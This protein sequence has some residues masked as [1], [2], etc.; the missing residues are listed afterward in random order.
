MKKILALLLA[1]AVLASMLSIS[2]LGLSAEDFSDVPEDS[3]YYEDVDFMAL[4]EYMNGFPD[5]TFRPQD[6]LTREQVA[7]IFARVWGADVSNNDVAPYDDVTPGRYSAG[8]IQWLKDTGLTTGT[9]NNKFSPKGTL[10]RQELATFTARFVKLYLEQHPDVKLVPKN[11][12]DGFNDMDKAADW[13]VESIEYCREQGL[14]YGFPDGDFRPT[15]NTTRA[16][17][18]AVFHRM[19]IE[20]QIVPAEP[21][22]GP[23]PGPVTPDEIDPED[24]IGLA[25]KAAAEHTNEGIIANMNGSYLRDYAELEIKDITRDGWSENDQDGKTRELTLEVNGSLDPDIAVKLLHIASNVLLPYLKV[26]N[27]DWITTETGD[28]KDEV[29]KA[30]FHDYAQSLVDDF[31]SLTGLELTG[32]DAKELAQKLFDDYK[33]TVAYSQAQ[34]L[35]NAEQ[36]IYRECFLNDGLYV[37]GEAVINVNGKDIATVNV[38]KDGKIA[39]LSISKWTAIKNFTLEMA[40]E[41]YHSLQT[42]RTDYVHTLNATSTVKVTFADSAVTEVSDKTATF[43][44]DYVLN[45]KV[46]MSSDLFGYKFDTSYSSGRNCVAVNL[47]TAFMD[48]LATDVTKVLNFIIDKKYDELYAKLVKAAG[49]ELLVKGIF[50]SVSDAAGGELTGENL[51]AAVTTVLGDTYKEEINTLVTYVNS[52][53]D[54]L[55]DYMLSRIAYRIN[56]YLDPATEDESEAL[57][58]AMLPVVTLGDIAAI[59]SNPEL[60]S[61]ITS[62]PFKPIDRVKG[63]IKTYLPD[64]ASIYI[65]EGQ[66]EL[67]KAILGDF[68]NAAGTAA[69]VAEF[70]KLVNASATLQGLSL[71]SLHDSPLLIGAK[72]GSYG[73]KHFRLAVLFDGV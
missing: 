13:A 19:I 54:S 39:T 3:W 58:K 70:C 23:G 34:G 27:G 6:L 28:A 57:V 45:V 7:V 41:L 64:S 26:D 44:H 56:A 11:V 21:T 72:V 55:K 5:G 52:V 43:P 40:R 20:L 46:N 17:I 36:S 31:N 61:F 67:N 12:V 24:L 10:T 73:P 60:N 25:V 63:Y 1:V 29:I 53:P 18:A 30:K 62:R 65:G 71:Q 8:A 66:Q 2:A 50:V 68:L 22:P 37:A 33:S 35:V 14:L 32:A 59:L 4:H 9:G 16:Q 15:D 51:I 49:S 48:E 38:N 69:T 42:P 47:S